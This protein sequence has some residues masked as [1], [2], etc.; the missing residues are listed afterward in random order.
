MNIEC[1]KA[2]YQM[3]LILSEV[4]GTFANTEGK[5]I[6][7]YL[8]KFLPKPAD[9]DGEMEFISTLPVTEFATQ[10]SRLAMEFLKGSTEEEQFELLEF[11]HKLVKA[12][13]NVSIN[14]NIYMRLLYKLWD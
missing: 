10:F 3:L 2:G 11:A 7:D 8:Q 5:V 6:V 9:L 1:A 14:E 13:E 4:D 12:D